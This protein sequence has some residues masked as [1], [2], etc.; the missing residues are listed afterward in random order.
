MDLPPAFT[1]NKCAL[2]SACLISASFLLMGS[3]SP[4]AVG[5]VGL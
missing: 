3:V 4:A 2:S 5:L 1:G